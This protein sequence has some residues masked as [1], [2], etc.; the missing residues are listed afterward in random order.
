M[1]P[2]T[3]ILLLAVVAIV[4]LFVAQPF[5]RHWRVKV[6][7]SREISA[8][9]AERE[10][11]LSA[12]VELDFD[13]GIGKIPAE[14][15]S[16]QRASLIEKGSEILRQLDEIQGK[17]PS[18]VPVSI[19]PEYGDQSPNKPTD[20]DLEDLIGKRRAHRQQKTAGFCPNCGKPIL[21]SDRFCPSCGQTLNA[22]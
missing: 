4:G 14:E 12:L 1:E 17:Q 2:G 13:N 20:E 19:E 9:L 5:A 16:I 11:T 22:K 7:S 8:L 15:Y 21:Q 6:Q 18:P 10:R 3:I